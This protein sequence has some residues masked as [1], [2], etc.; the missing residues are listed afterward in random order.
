[1]STALPEALAKLVVDLQDRGFVIAHEVLDRVSEDEDT[2]VVLE[3]SDGLVAG[4]SH[5]C[6]FPWRV[7]GR[8]RGRRPLLLADVQRVAGDGGPVSD[9]PPHLEQTN[10]ERRQLMVDVLDRL[11]GDPT[12]QREVLEATRRWKQR[13]PGD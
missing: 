11:H 12:A 1:M 6:A 5:P 13:K 7:G 2:A 3:L 8:D 9:E 4:E 10:D